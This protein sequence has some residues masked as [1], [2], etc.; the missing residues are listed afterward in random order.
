MVSL[1]Y[2][3][4]FLVAVLENFFPPLP[5]EL[6]F[7]F[8]GFIA[9][10]GHFQI[11]P[12]VLTG[13]FG[14][15]VGAWFWYGL[16]YLLG[17][18]NLKIWLDRYGPFLRVHFSDVK[19]AERWFARF[20]G[21]AVLLGRLVPLVR[22]LISV[23]AGFVRMPLFQFNLYSFVGSLLW[24]GWLSFAGFLLGENWSQIVPVV[25]N[26]ELAMELGLVLLIGFL[27]FRLYSHRH[28]SK[29]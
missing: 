12:V 3:G 16:G 9:G 11:F 19:T 6:I 27:G 10:Q 17:R 29:R 14:A 8:A 28:Q 25:Q 2:G 4:I 24:I 18:A 20:G 22:T 7:P 1:G 5:S 26:Y 23:P 15:L 21:P 13:T